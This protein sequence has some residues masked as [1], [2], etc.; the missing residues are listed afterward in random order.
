MS[1]W[2]GFWIRTEGL[3]TPDCRKLPTSEVDPISWT[4]RGFSKVDPLC[5]RNVET[6]RRRK[7]GA[8]GMGERLGPLHS[9]G[10]NG[11]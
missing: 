11:S 8:P 4:I 6:R 2:W 3:R 7:E 1:I 10:D 5:D 9:P